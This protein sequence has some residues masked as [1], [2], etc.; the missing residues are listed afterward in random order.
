M[1]KSDWLIYLL[2][3]LETLVF[4][5]PV[6]VY[7]SWIAGAELYEIGLWRAFL[8]GFISYMVAASYIRI[9]DR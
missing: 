8:I 1:R 7:L 5:I 6:A 3:F 9:R 2:D 4:A